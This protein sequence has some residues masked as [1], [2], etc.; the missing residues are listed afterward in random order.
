MEDDKIA[1]YYN[2]PFISIT[3]FN[4]N[5]LP[6]KSYRTLMSSREYLRRRHK[7]STLIIKAP[8]RNVVSLIWCFW[9]VFK[10]IK[11]LRFA[12]CWTPVMKLGLTW[13]SGKSLVLLRL[14]KWTRF[15]WLVVTSA[16]LDPCIFLLA[17]ATLDGMSDWTRP[18]VNSSLRKG[19]TMLPLKEAVLCLLFKRLSLDP[20]NLN[21]FCLDSNLPF[22][23][24]SSL[25]ATN[26]PSLVLDW[27]TMSQREP[28]CNLG[29]LLESWLLLEDQLAVM[30]KRVFAH[31]QVVCQCAHSFFMYIFI[32]LIK[33]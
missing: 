20:I 26:F 14:W 18:M 32:N 31:L 4:I 17:K 12:L 2:I 6:K 3:L 22:S 5:H 21:T 28:M 33:V 9:H 8:F 19:V 11:S 24:L 1:A 10:Q 27:E 25:S 7:L 15:L 13:L 29:V 16:I 30:T 23:P